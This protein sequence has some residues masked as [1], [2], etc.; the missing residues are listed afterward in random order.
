MAKYEFTFKGV[1]QV[2]EAY[3]T[4]ALVYI[5]GGNS[6][7]AV[8]KAPYKTGNLYNR[9]KDYNEVSKMA[10]YRATTSGTK[11]ELPQVTISLQFAPP[12]ATYGKWVEWGNGT[13]VGA[14]NP[15]PFAEDAA[16]SR[17]LQNAVNEAMVGRDGII[18]SY[19]SQVKGEL[20]S[21][22]AKVKK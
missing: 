16:N 10:T 7:W 13:G 12:G 18:Q 4:L 17:E 6:N 9:I 2:A 22:W 8:N 20:D 11:Y 15:R 5:R 1:E 21:V 14:G 3:K 19:L